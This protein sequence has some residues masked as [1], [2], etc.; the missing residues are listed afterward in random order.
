MLIRLWSFMCDH[1]GCGFTEDIGNHYLAGAT[2]DLSSYGWTVT[3]RGHNA[4]HF[5]PDHKPV[6]S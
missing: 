3:G 4:R 6:S 5:C 1:A 2:S